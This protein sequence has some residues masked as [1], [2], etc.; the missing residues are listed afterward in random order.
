MAEA[1][2][3]LLLDEEARKAMSERA[4]ALS[5]ERFSADA[6]VPRY[7]ALYRE[8]VEGAGAST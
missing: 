5:V 6:V 8:I 3:E 7:E 4:R 1:G 2:C